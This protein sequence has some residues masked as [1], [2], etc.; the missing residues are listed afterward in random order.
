MVDSICVKRSLL[1][2]LQDIRPENL[3]GVEVSGN[4]GDETPALD[5]PVRL[6]T[7]IIGRLLAKLT[8]NFIAERRV[9]VT[10]LKE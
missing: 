10:C 3:A 2:E 5:G 6:G 4:N 1:Q 7:L 9:V 8:V